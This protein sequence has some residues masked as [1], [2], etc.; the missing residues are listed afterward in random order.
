MGLKMINSKSSEKAIENVE[1]IE[2]IC[3]FG[4]SSS[5]TRIFVYFSSVRSGKQPPSFDLKVFL[6]PFVDWWLLLL[7]LDRAPQ[8]FE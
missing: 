1:Y 7:D 6:A 2:R 3:G 8:S 4:Q 5:S